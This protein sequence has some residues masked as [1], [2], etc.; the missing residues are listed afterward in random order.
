MWKD[1]TIGQVR[2]VLT[3]LGGVAVA[4]GYMDEGVAS[5]LVDKAV[6]AAGALMI[7]VGSLASALDK[8]QR[9]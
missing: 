8:K 5:D 1:I 7:L 4:F 2:H 6:T 3:A 9:Q